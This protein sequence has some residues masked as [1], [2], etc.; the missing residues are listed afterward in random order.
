MDCKRILPKDFQNQTQ[1]AHLKP[2][3]LHRVT[4]FL[5][6]YCYAKRLPMSKEGQVIRRYFSDRYFMETDSGQ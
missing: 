4:A 1:N 5:G 2:E 6:N 3:I